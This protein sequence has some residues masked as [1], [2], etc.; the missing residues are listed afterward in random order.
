M[1]TAERNQA[2]A[3]LGNAQL[4]A[5]GRGSGGGAPVGRAAALPAKRRGT[6]YC[7]TACGSGKTGF[8]G[9]GV[10]PPRSMTRG[11]TSAAA[12]DTKS[13]EQGFRSAIASVPPS[14]ARSIDRNGRLPP[15]RGKNTGSLLPS[16]RNTQ[17]PSRSPKRSPRS[18]ASTWQ[19]S[20]SRSPCASGLWHAQQ[21]SVAKKSNESGRASR[22]G[23]RVSGQPSHAAM[24]ASKPP[25]ASPL[26]C[27]AASQ[28][29]VMCVDCRTS[30]P[31]AGGGV[32][33]A[34]AACC[35]DAASTPPAR[36]AGAVAARRCRCASAACSLC[37]HVEAAGPRTSSAS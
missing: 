25:P 36:A 8:S 34:A 4:P 28:V 35:E 7:G 22:V 33:A 3:T 10:A 21:V 37:P 32:G 2:A 23:S 31:S 18:E 12:D 15:P 14:V 26:L 1:D 27:L 11:P 16:A 24:C 5:S 6:A 20:T 17:R 30:R 9:A 13:P 19:P 29:P